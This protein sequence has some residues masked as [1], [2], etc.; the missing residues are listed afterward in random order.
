MT[1]Q[2]LALVGA[3]GGVG[4]TRLVVEC[5]ATLARAGRDVAVIDTA[6][7]TQGTAAYLDRQVGTDATALATG[8]AT[9]EEALY[10]HSTNLPGRFAVCPARAPF[11]RLARAKTPGAAERLGDKIAAASLGHDA[12]LVDVPPVAANQA[13]AAV[14]AVE[15]VA[16]V[17]EDTRRGVRALAGQ[18]ERLADLGRPADATVVNR[19]DTG[20][21]EADVAVPES[22]VHAP[23]ACCVHPGDGSAFAP[24]VAEAVE[25]LLDISLDLGFGD[26]GLLAR[27]VG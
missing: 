23:Q 21:V 2:T 27:V 8:A 24:A 10:E 22:S 12:V 13:L 25:T 1:T 6:F 9:L 7:A 4:T 18:R 5:A 11:E 3:A 17:T 20:R 19:A 16:V 26:R 14:E 15:T